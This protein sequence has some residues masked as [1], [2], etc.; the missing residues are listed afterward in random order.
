MLLEKFVFNKDHA[1][2]LLS[3]KFYNFKVPVK[4][5]E[6]S[7]PEAYYF[8]C[9]SFPNGG[10]LITD[11]AFLKIDE[12]IRFSIMSHATPLESVYICYQTHE[13]TNNVIGVINPYQHSFSFPL[14]NDKEVKFQI[15]HVF[16]IVDSLDLS[17]TMNHRKYLMDRVK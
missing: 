7:I 2:E 16:V 8:E 10:W 4:V 11:L 13:N 5:K 12:N 15:K 9:D 17:S 3:G 1:M 6:L 14:K